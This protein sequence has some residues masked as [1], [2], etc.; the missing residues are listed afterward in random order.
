MIMGTCWDSLNRNSGKSDLSPSSP[1]PHIPLI[2]HHANT[3]ALPSR[4]VMRYP[5]DTQAD[6]RID[7]AGEVVTVLH[8][9]FDDR[10]AVHLMNFIV[11]LSRSSWTIGSKPIRIAL[12]EV[13][14][15]ESHIATIVV[16]GDAAGQFMYSS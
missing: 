9:A 12:C 2:T 4:I 7:M 8:Q 10:C 14:N 13:R 15:D 1:R 5:I 11:D 16:D 3:V 6:I